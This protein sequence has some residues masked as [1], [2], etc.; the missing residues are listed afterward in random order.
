[1][2]HTPRDELDRVPSFDEQQRR[3]GP[4][5]QDLRIPPGRATRCDACGAELD[6]ASLRFRCKTCPP[7]A[8]PTVATEILARLRARQDT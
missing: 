5:P 2:A 1:M 3:Q 7:P 6:P 8:L 4:R